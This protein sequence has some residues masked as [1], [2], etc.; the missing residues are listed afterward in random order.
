VDDWTTVNLVAIGEPDSL[1]NANP[2]GLTTEHLALALHAPRRPG[3]GG[4]A[5]ARLERLRPL[6]APQ[7][8][9]D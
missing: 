9:S 6:F 4:L 7:T 1:P 3:A 8:G 5:A 2:A